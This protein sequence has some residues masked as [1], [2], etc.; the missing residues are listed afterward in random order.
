MNEQPAAP[1]SAWAIVE[2]FGHERIAGEV[3]EQTIGAASFVRVD[4]PSIDG[5]PAWTRLY[6]EKA[7]Y[8]IT[9]VDE[10]TARLAAAQLRARPINIYIALPALNSPPADP[11]PPDDDDEIDPNDDDDDGW[12][13]DL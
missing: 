5:S 4:V 9:P 13:R 11:G 7:I 2:I 1:F 12:E 10:A 3:S 6:G 8:S